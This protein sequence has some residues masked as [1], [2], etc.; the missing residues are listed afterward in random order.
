MNKIIKE[1]KKVIEDLEFY[2]DNVEKGVT[3]VPDFMYK[4]IIAEV[5]AVCNK[6]AN[7]GE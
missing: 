6:L 4:K 7:L 1:L 5:K 3:Y 2:E